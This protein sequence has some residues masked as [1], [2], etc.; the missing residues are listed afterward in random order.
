MLFVLFWA[1]LYMKCEFIFGSVDEFK[2]MFAIRKHNRSYSR[3]GL[4]PIMF[5]SPYF[6]RQVRIIGPYKLLLK[7][8][9]QI[10]V[11]V[12]FKTWSSMSNWT[13]FSAMQSWQTQLVFELV[14]QWSMIIDI[15]NLIDPKESISNNAIAANDVKSRIEL[16]HQKLSI[17]WKKRTYCQHQK[18]SA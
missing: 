6:W 17:L 4:T 2:M 13:N 14:F 11:P 1:T 16:L 9:I 15:A 7:R 10:Q 12:C 5:Q 18:S 8:W 3:R